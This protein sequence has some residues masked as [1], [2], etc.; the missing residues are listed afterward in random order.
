MASSGRFW[1][2]LYVVFFAMVPVS[3]SGSGSGAYGNDNV[4]KPGMVD[5]NS[6]CPLPYWDN[7]TVEVL[8]R[9]SHYRFN[10]S[11]IASIPWVHGDSRNELN[12]PTVTCKHHAGGHPRRRVVVLLIDAITRPLVETKYPLLMNFSRQDHM[13]F[14]FKN[15]HT[16]GRNSPPN[17]QALY[18]GIFPA[19]KSTTNAPKWLHKTFNQSGY[20]TIHADDV[21]EPTKVSGA[22]TAL[23][24]T[25]PGDVMPND[26][27]LCSPRIE[28]IDSEPSCSASS[29]LEFVAQAVEQHAHCDL[30]VTVNP[31]HEHTT[32]FWYTK[33]DLW[34]VRFLERV[35]G[36]NTIVVVLSDH[37]IHFGNPI[38]SQL[39]TAY[40]TNP[41]LMILWPKRMRGTTSK[42][43]QR[44]TSASL[45]T[46]LN[47]YAFLDAIA[48]GAPHSNVS[49]ASPNFAL[50]Q[51]CKEAFIPSTECRCLHS[52]SCTFAA[53][54]EAMLVLEDQLHAV[55]ADPHCMS[56]HKSEFTMVSCTGEQNAHIASFTRDHRY[57]QLQWD[58]EAEY[59]TSLGQLTVWK[60]DIDPCRSKVSNK[61]WSLCICNLTLS[62]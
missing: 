41:F 16:H 49:L 40:R 5:V 56:L 19:A 51:T 48:S 24:G 42:A 14:H 59:L 46:H 21:C 35:V 15:H 55:N 39:G 53:E 12:V 61:L 31:N 36:H 3:M 8:A 1:S 52:G 4:L 27:S 7:A 43:L 57:Y 20:T 45:T 62:S 18:A 54:Q 26:R 33:A 44:S 6:N 9:R 58:S 34:V 29:S 30:F 38:M 17:K 28:C 11:D 10:H 13:A 23:M 37:G 60:K 32:R 47:V 25:K 2:L 22:L 50:N